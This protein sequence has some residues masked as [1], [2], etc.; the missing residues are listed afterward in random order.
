MDKQTEKLTGIIPPLVTPLE[1]DGRIDEDS[2][3][4]LISHCINGGVSGIFVLGSCGEGTSLTAEQKKRTVRTALREAEGKVPVLVGTLE[5]ST[6]KIAEEIKEYEDM[7]AQYFVSAVPYYLSPEGQEGIICHYRFLAEHTRG[8]VIV[9]NIP[10]YVHYD[11]LPETMKKL[12]DIP[13]I[14]AVKDSTGD[15]GLFQKA[16]F[17]NNHGG[18]LSGN[19]DLCGAAMLFGADGCVPCLA[20]V[21]PEF[22]SRFYQ[23]AAEGNIEK[24]IECQRAVIKMKKVLNLAGNWIAAVKYLC[25]RKGLIQPYTTRGITKISEKEKR[26]IESYLSENGELNISTMKTM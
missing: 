23:Y 22:Y 4:K 3:K 18:M 25:F 24:V 21:Y 13:G 8:R 19:E 17:L 14:I 26:N 12:L 2:L 6:E 1:P 20:N 9:Y 5:T 10:P 7:G 11:I 15:W 16:L